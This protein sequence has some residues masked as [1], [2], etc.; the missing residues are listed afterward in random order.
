[1]FRTLWDGF[2]S[3]EGGR[4]PVNR[5]AVIDT[6]FLICLTDKNRVSHATALQ[7]YRYFLES[8]VLMLLPTVVIAEFAIKQSPDDLPL[9]NFFILPFNYETAKICGGLD[10]LRERKGNANL[11]QRDAVKDD[12]K[13]IAHV[14]E[15]NSSFLV[16]EDSETMERYCNALREK[17]KTAFSV[18]QIAKPFDAAY[19]NGTGQRDLC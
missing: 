12:F 6:T 15:N 18:V 4:N 17:G 7:Y 11:G 5:T 13:I 1:M 14:I 3:R 16:T 8:D 2:V 10:A 9:R 19:V